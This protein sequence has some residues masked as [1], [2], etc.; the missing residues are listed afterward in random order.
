MYPIGAGP[1]IPGSTASDTAVHWPVRA[2]AAARTVNR[3]R[4]PTYKEAV[5][6]MAQAAAVLA[7]FGMPPGAGSAPQP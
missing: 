5:N 6:A 4:A 2:P 7:G 1:P 3:D